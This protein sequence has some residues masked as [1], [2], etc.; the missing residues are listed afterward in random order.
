MR[1][2][3]KG[4]EKE[5]RVGSCNKKIVPAPLI[6]YL[7]II[8]VFMRYDVSITSCV[9]MHL[10]N[11][12]MS[13]SVLFV[14]FKDIDDCRVSRNLVVEPCCKFSCLMICMMIYEHLFTYL[15]RMG[16]VAIT[17][18]VGTNGATTLSRIN[19]F[20]MDT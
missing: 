3:R 11:E 15:L 18:E 17:V 12:F 4:K 13:H 2:G 14:H 5:W 7:C 16:S 19:F 6:T 9:F 1:E 10:P 20:C 8:V